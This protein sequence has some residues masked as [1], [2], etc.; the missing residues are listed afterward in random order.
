MTKTNT[1]DKEI[2]ISDDAD[3]A[4]AFCQYFSS[5][6]TIDTDVSTV[7]DYDSSHINASSKLLSEL[8]FDE[9]EI[10]QALDK[11]NVYKSPGPDGLHPKVLYETKNVIVSPLK[12]IFKARDVRKTEILF[13]FSVLKKTNR[14]RT[15]QKFDIRS[16]SFRHKLR[17]NSQFM[18][19]VTKSYFT[20]IQMCT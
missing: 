17:A 16:D 15:I 6:F 20:C 3:K 13:G 9:Y 18:L 8:E 19:K 10:V 11:L 1:R 7:E 4:S 12:I 5:V 14:H 2:I